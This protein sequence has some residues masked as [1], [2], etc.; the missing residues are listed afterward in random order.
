MCLHLGHFEHSDFKCS[1]IISEHPPKAFFIASVFEKPGNFY[2]LKVLY[3]EKECN[4]T[5]LLHSLILKSRP[6]ISI[7]YRDQNSASSALLFGDALVK[8]DEDGEDESF[9]HG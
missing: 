2:S 6:E 1:E 9:D 4:L 3:L 5:S 7:K 8:G